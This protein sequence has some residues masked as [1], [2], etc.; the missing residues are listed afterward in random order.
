LNTILTRDNGEN[1]LGLIGC[2]LLMVA[3]P[4]VAALYGIICACDGAVI[5]AKQVW[6]ARKARKP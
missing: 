5:L 2:V 3:I 1:V 6:I 4:L